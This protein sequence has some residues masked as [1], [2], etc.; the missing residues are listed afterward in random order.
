MKR[1]SAFFLSFLIGIGLI[2]LSGDGYFFWLSLEFL[3]LRFLGLLASRQIGFECTA[4][5]FV[6]NTVGNLIFLVGVVGLV[7]S[8]FFIWGYF[9]LVG[10]VLKL[11]VYPL[12]F[13][14]PPVCLYLDDLIF[15]VFLGPLKIGPLLGAWY[16]IPMGNG[17]NLLAVWAAFAAFISGIAGIIQNFMSIVFAYSSILR[18]GW[19]LLVVIYS[20]FGGLFF[21]LLYSITLSIAIY[22]RRVRTHRKEDPNAIL[23]LVLVFL[24]GAPAGAVFLAKWGV[25]REIII[26]LGGVYLMVVCT[27]ICISIFTAAGL[28]LKIILGVFSYRKIRAFPRIGKG[29]GII[30]GI[31]LFFFISG[32]AYC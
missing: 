5:Y 1:N 12:H 20:L 7:Q 23:L 9:G 25:V 19:I 16:I 14:I 31:G 15:C 18:S 32:C 11:G 22:I 4:K 28:Y 3:S 30:T 13:W 29:E 27:G 8:D 21:W 6:P 17:N 10:I 26:E 2:L 24:S